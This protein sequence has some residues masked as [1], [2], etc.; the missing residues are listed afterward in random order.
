[1]IYDKVSF[2][3]HST[4]YWFRLSTLMAMKARDRLHIEEQILHFSLTTDGGRRGENQ[5]L[6]KRNNTRP[7]AGI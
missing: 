7:E 5:K 2:D 4:R 1:M 3:V 6:G